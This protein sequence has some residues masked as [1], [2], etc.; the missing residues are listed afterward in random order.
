MM[1]AECRLNFFLVLPPSALDE[2]HV[3]K[4][5]TGRWKAKKI[6]TDAPKHSID[7][8]STGLGRTLVAENTGVIS[9]SGH[10]DG[11]EYFRYA[12]H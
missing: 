7:G 8:M 5:S 12:S 1:D 9:T 3:N 6:P 11:L 10:N 2:S 4:I